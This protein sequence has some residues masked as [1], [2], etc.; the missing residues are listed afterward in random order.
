MLHATE[1]VLQEFVTRRMSSIARKREKQA[2]S[3]KSVERGTENG[4]S[5]IQ[6]ADRIQKIHLVDATRMLFSHDPPRDGR[7]AG[8]ARTC[9]SRAAGDVLLLA[10]N[11]ILR[12]AETGL[13]RV[14]YKSSRGEVSIHISPVCI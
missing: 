2:R 7:R 14:L 13:A 5:N 4:I 6:S 8:G 1:S 11:G 12:P 3:G 10:K 9:A